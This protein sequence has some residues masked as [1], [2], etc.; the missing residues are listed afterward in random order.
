MKS[1]NKCTL[2]ACFIVLFATAS[3]VFAAIKRQT[4]RNNT[5]GNVND[6]HLDWDPDTKV[7]SAKLWH[8]GNS[9]DTDMDDINDASERI[10]GAAGSNEDEADWAQNSFGTIAA[11]GTADIDYGHK[12]KIDASQSYWTLAGANVGGLQLV[13]EPM[14]VAFAGGQADATFKNPSGTLTI[15]YTN[16]SLWRNNDAGHLNSE[17]FDQPT[18]T[19]VPGTP[20]SIVLGPGQQQT[21]SF[22]AIDIEGYQL[23]RAQA[24]DNAAPGVLYTLITA[25]CENCVPTLSE[26]GLIAFGLTLLAAASVIAMRRKAVS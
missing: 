13:G 3:S 6:L 8:T 20:A 15:T 23:V 7:S 18:G 4:I 9:V 1:R 26:W 21:V 24:F 10:A 17:K 19:L 14:T 5:G 16:I 22:G 11:G 25:D 12:G 2:I